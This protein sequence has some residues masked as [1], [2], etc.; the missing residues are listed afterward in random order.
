MNNSFISFREIG[1]N[2]NS[3]LKCQDDDMQ[4]DWNYPNGEIVPLYPVGDLN[5]KVISTILYAS[6]NTAVTASYLFREGV[7]SRL[8]RYFCSTSSQTVYIRIGKFS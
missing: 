3:S 1:R 2:F 6:R 4:A 8:G 5:T 7:P